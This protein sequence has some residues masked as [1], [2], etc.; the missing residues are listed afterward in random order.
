MPFGKDFMKEALKRIYD[1]LNR[2]LTI[3]LLILVIITIFIHNFSLDLSKFILLGI[4]LFRLFSKDKLKRS[5][6]N[7]IFLNFIKIITFQSNKI[8]RKTTYKEKKKQTFVYKKCPK[9]KTTL[10]LPLP[11][12]RGI[13]H[14]KCPNCGN[15]VTILSLRC[16]KPEKV[17]VEVVKKDKRDRRKIYGN[18]Y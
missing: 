7:E 3:I 10:K 13:N 16:K 12:K 4:I 2:F 6:E 9:C 5:K 8:V 15:R 18:K 17:K 1:E 11:K 14:A